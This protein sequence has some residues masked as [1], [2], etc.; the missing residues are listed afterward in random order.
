MP[1]I[2]QILVI[3]VERPD[4]EI[5][6]LGDRSFILDDGVHDSEFHDDG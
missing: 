1:Q 2:G 4:F 6:V 3:G 5:G